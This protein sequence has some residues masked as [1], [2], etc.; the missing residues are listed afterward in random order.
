[1]NTRMKTLRKYYNLLGHN[2]GFEPFAYS[3]NNVAGTEVT[4]YK[5]LGNSTNVNIQSTIDGKT[6]T[7]IGA[8]TF[9]D[10]TDIHG[11]TIPNSVTKIN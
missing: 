1:M 10:M 9:M 3:E 8:F 11:A 7:E 2:S 5:Y 6:I 4:T